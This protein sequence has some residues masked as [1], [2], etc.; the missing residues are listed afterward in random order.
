MTDALDS[1]LIANEQCVSLATAAVGI[2]LGNGQSGSNVHEWRR[3]ESAESGALKPGTPIATFLDRRGNTSDRYAGGGAG[4]P[5]A[6]LDHAAVFEGYARDGN[7]KIVGM[8]V[9]EQYHGSGGI[10]RQTYS[11][12]QGWGEGNAS[13][14]HA[15][16]TDQGYLGGNRNPMGGGSA[17]AIAAG[18]S[19]HNAQRSSHVASTS[20]AMHSHEAA[21][22]G[23]YPN[24]VAERTPAPPMNGRMIATPA[25]GDSVPVTITTTVTV[26]AA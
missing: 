23:G 4:T 8:N 12:G 21:R 24:R 25:G 16:R 10:H 15:I 17:I 22:R 5:G 2:R 11:F 7:G 26:T 20:H 14:Y 6:H 13:N 1:A 3:G 19:S 9:S 18:P